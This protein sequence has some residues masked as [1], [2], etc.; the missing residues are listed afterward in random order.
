MTL[1]VCDTTFEF[2]VS[3][4]ICGSTYY[5]HFHTHVP[6]QQKSMPEK[7]LLKLP[8]KIE[9]GAN[10][11]QAKQ[12]PTLTFDSSEDE[13]DLEVLKVVSVLFITSVLGSVG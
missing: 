4:N 12:S 7:K 3:N 6:F 2:F 8:T 1:C 11:K 13:G 9:K 5:Q 10:K